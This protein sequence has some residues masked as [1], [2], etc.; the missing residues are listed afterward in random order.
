MCVILY[1]RDIIVSYV[2]WQ[3]WGHVGI[4][5]VSSSTSFKYQSTDS[6]CQNFMTTSII[7]VYF[8]FYVFFLFYIDVYE[9]LQQHLFRWAHLLIL[10]VE[11]PAHI[12]MQPWALCKPQDLGSWL[13]GSEFGEVSVNELVAWIIFEVTWSWMR[14]FHLQGNLAV[15]R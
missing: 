7:D 4:S 13:V 11:N 10:T 9:I 6:E 5:V 14:D 12:S 15:Q 3:Q 1:W 8:A 2:R